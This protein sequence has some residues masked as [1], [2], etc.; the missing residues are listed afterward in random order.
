MNV[1]DM[2][3]LIGCDDFMPPIGSVGEIVGV[4]L[5]CG[6]FDYEVSFPDHPC[7]VEDP[8]WLIPPYWLMKINPP[9]QTVESVCEL[10]QPK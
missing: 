10:E 5:H 1:G 2:V 3:M 8:N 6:I 9:K 4:D 7:P